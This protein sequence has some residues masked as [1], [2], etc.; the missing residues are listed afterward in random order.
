MSDGRT[1]TSALPHGPAGSD[2]DSAL[3][4]TGV[5]GV[6]VLAVAFSAPLITAIAAPALAVAFWRN[7]FG[8]IAGAPFTL[9]TRR[10]ELRSLLGPQRRTLYLA[11][12]AGLALALHF[13]LWIPSL[14]LTS[15]TA[16]T[17][18][19]TTTPLWTVVMTRLLGQHVPRGV[20][21]GVVVAVTGVLVVTGVDASGSAQAL[22]GDLLALGGGAAG[23]GYVVAGAEVRRTVGTATYTLVAYTT[24]AVVLLAVCLVSG[25]S[26]SG[27][28]A[29]TWVELALLTLTAQLLGHSLL[30]RALRSAGA[31]TVALAILLEVPGA[32][33]VAWVWLGQVPP[34]AVVPGAALVLAGIAVVIRSQSTSRR[35]VA[36]APAP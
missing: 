15:V 18:L 32:S 3:V 9:A 1:S 27:Y 6:G 5:I 36:E 34:L 29:R 8:A 31:T 24:C 13:G 10:D 28:S 12:V 2:H 26:L 30:N 4:T 25:T 16:S 17:A 21:L 35:A 7:A 33:L 19:A 23:A 14:R 20:V 11:V 22:Q